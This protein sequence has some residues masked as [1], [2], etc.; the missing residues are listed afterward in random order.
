MAAKKIIA[1]KSF[2]G[3]KIYINDILHI[4]FLME[5]YTGIQSWYE[6]NKTKIYYI[7]ISF[8]EGEQ[9]LLEYTEFD[10]WKTI[11][12]LIDENL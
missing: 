9:L 5:N 10:N 2:H 4:S 7:E 3:I 11:L 6:G 8:K 1:K 12:K